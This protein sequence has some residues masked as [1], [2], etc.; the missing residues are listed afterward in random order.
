MSGTDF[1]SKQGQLENLLKLIELAPWVSLDTEANSMYGYPEKVCLIQLSTESVDSIVDPLAKGLDV[2]PL[3]K[4]LEKKPL[5][6]HG[7]DYDLRLLYKGYKFR[8][9]QLFDTMLAGKLLGEESCGLASLCES[10]LGIHLIKKYQKAD[11]GRRPI[12]QDYLNYA[13]KDAFYL[14]ELKLRLEKR[15]LQCG[16]LEWHR[17]NCQ[18]LI[19]DCTHPAKPEP[20]R[21]WRI[22]GCENFSRRELGI[23][24][25]LWY[26]REAEGIRNCRP[27]FF[28]MRPDL[29]VKIAKVAAA[30][31]KYTHLL[32]HYSPSM[33]GRLLQ[34]ISNAQKIPPKKLP[35][36]LKR[37]HQRF[38]PLQQHQ[39]EYLTKVRDERAVT[40]KM[41][42]VLIASR[43][44]LVGC[45]RD[46]EACH[47]T[48]WQ[49]E[50]LGFKKNE[51]GKLA[52]T[53]PDFQ[54][55]PLPVTSKK[56][57]TSSQAA[58]SGKKT[59]KNPQSK[60]KEKDKK[61]LPEPSKET[62]HSVP[63]KRKEKTIPVVK[64]KTKK[65]EQPSL[66]QEKR[67]KKKIFK[68]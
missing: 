37:E 27:L 46:Q 15:L 36:Y 56:E 28:I 7:A 58:P 3:L 5:I 45:I 41:D 1:V 35:M 9:R 6:M 4:L 17:Q 26:W 54:I 49:K 62:N 11:W 23:L 30:N 2:T 14:N 31:K 67:D 42:P 48:E 16:R 51:S 22:G 59:G 39:L 61:P 29:L 52:F 32:P 38:T 10:Y 44:D 47:L 34:T 24:R 8:P 50:V 57:S 64:S 60:K 68:K 66:K 40:L 20:S 12:P 18:R 25:E 43:A 55:S 19:K 33:K 21:E 13:I 53:F 65:Q 63:S